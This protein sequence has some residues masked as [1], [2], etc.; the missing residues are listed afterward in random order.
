MSFSTPSISG[1]SPVTDATLA[2]QQPRNPFAADGPFANLNLSADQQQQISSILS[3]AQSQ[4][5]SP[6]QVQSQINSV[7]TPTQQQQLQTD[8]SQLKAHHHHGGHGGHG[9]QDQTASLAQQLNLTSS[10]ESQIQQL[11]QT[12][13]QNGTAPSDLLSQIDGVLTTDQQTQLATLLSGSAYTSSGAQAAT[14]PS[15]VLNTSA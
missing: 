11:L 3:D 15:Y 8:V 5:L 6:S 10:Q 12:A 14:T 1:S 7:L 13:Q 4:G 2:S 9:D